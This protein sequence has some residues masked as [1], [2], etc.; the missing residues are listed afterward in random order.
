MGE[1]AD[2][3]QGSAQANTAFNPA[4]EQ[5]RERAFLHF[6]LKPT[7]AAV[8]DEEV[9][10]FRENPEEIDEFTAPVNVHKAFLWIGAL[11]GTVCVAFS[12]M[13]KYT[14]FL[15]FLPASINEFLVD[16]VFEVGVALIGAAVTAYILGILLNQQQENAAKWRAEI[17]R[18]IDQSEK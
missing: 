17:W 5:A 12:K 2:G 18:R 16:I 11:L 7:A 8:S 10:Y 6:F 15:D 14:T 1:P 4:Q 9:D 3:A 13:L